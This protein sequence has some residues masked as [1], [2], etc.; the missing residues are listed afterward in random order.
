MAVESG[1]ME[2]LAAQGMDAL[3]EDVGLRS[4][5][6]TMRGSL[7]PVPVVGVVRLLWPVLLE[8]R[9]G[10]NVHHSLWLSRTN[11]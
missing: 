6:L 9:G 2:Q 3:S 11:C 5:E 1:V 10:N 4:L 8:V 7:G